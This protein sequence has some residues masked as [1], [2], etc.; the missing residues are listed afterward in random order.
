VTTEERITKR[1]AELEQVERDAVMQITIIRNLL[2]EL[3]SLLTP[4]AAPP[5]DSLGSISGAPMGD[6]DA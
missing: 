3:R 2:N 6:Q 1:I 5:T 4:A